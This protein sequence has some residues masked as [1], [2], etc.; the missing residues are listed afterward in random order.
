MLV[1][2]QV[3]VLAFGAWFQ[4]PRAQVPL[5]VWPTLICSPKIW[6]CLEA[7]SKSS[8]FF[9]SE[10][11]G[12][13]SRLVRF[14]VQVVPS[15]SPVG[16]NYILDG[17]SRLTVLWTKEASLFRANILLIAHKTTICCQPFTL[18]SG[19]SQSSARRQGR[20][21]PAQVRFFNPIGVR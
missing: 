17:L 11:V 20:P 16:Y 3:A 15:F 1:T 2:A 10:I 4:S 9:I 19:A 18:F 13:T 6:H 8:V 12:G 5:R 7:E 14:L 21:G